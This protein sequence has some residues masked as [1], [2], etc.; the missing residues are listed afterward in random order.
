MEGWSFLEIFKQWLQIGV[1]MFHVSGFDKV[2]V[3]ESLHVEVSC[4]VFEEGADAISK[5]DMMK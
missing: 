4:D 1:D 5:L 3:E 2:E